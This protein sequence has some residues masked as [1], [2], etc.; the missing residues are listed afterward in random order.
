MTVC[1]FIHLLKFKC[2]NEVSHK[3]ISMEQ[4]KYPALSLL[5]NSPHFMEFRSS[6]PRLQQPAT[7]LYRK[8]DELSPHPETLF[9]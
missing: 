5:R 7:R 3:T 4:R 1:I 6:L 8:P 2:E 9:L